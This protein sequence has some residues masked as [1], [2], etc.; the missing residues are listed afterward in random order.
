MVHSS[1]KVYLKLSKKDSHESLLVFCVYVEGIYI[2]HK[3]NSYERKRESKDFSIVF[4]IIYDTCYY[5]LWVI[6]SKCAS[7]VVSIFLI[8][9]SKY[10]WT[11]DHNTHYCHLPHHTRQIPLFIVLREYMLLENSLKGIGYATILFESWE[12]DWWRE[13]QQQNHYKKR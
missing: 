11:M 2:C 3:E 8:C 5:F 12:W 10:L 6:F 7:L 1:L 9:W 13:Q 4:I